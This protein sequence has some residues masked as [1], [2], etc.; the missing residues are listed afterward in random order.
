MDKED[1]RQ[2][3]HT[4]IR[5]IFYLY[6]YNIHTLYIYKYIYTKIYIK[7]SAMRKKE[8]LPFRTWMDL[9]SILINEINRERQTLYGIT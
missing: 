5:Y 6:I 7:N 2:Y 4:Y 1:V 9:E 8:I 3:I